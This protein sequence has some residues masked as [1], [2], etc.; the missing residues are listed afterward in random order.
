MEKKPL[1]EQ[2][3][4]NPGKFGEWYVVRLRG[5]RNKDG[6]FTWLDFEVFDVPAAGPVGGVEKP[7]YYST[8]DFEISGVN[9]GL[10]EDIDAAVASVTG[11][12]NGDGC[13]QFWVHDTPVHFDS[14]EDLQAWTK[15][16]KETRDRALQVMAD[17]GGTW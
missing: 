4:V 17:S 13:T 3:E 12:V 15:T 11:F 16:I 5:E 8:D 2:F 10:T 9:G 1:V 14:D 7:N 6:E